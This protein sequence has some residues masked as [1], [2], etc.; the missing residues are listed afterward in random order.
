MILSWHYHL[1]TSYDIHTNPFIGNT[2]HLKNNFLQCLQITFKQ[3]CSFNKNHNT[4]EWTSIC[5][6]ACK[7]LRSHHAV[8]TRAEKTEDERLFYDSPELKSQDEPVSPKLERQIG[9]YRQPQLAEAETLLEPA[10][11]E[12][13]LSCLYLMACWKLSLSFNESLKLQEAPV[14]GRPLH[15]CELH[16]PEPC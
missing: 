8:L 12:E 6:L 3:E 16:Q 9:R 14:L 5:G 4:M 15:F 2:M 1:I 13:N 10:P 7:E 11:R